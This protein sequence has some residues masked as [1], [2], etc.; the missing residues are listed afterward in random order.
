MDVRGDH[1]GMTAFSEHAVMLSGMFMIDAWQ[2]SWAVGDRAVD[3][4]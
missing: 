3:F 4:L 2:P 1:A